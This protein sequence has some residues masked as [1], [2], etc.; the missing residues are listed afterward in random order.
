MRL[1]ARPV[2]AVSRV[3]MPMAS[4]MLSMPRREVVLPVPGPPVRA[5]TRH[6]AARL[7]AVLCR[8]A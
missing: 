5:M 6:L 4:Y 2:G 7:R 1:A 8:G 3:S